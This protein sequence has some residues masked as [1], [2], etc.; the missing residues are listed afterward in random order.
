MSDLSVMYKYE[1]IRA[2]V[3]SFMAACILSGQDNPTAWATEDRHCFDLLIH[4]TTAM[5]NEP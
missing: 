1:S 5:S 3:C 4:K 2:Y